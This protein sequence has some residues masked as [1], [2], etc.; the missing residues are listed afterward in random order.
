VIFDGLTRE[1]S[2]EE[3]GLDPRLQCF[4]DITHPIYQLVA[5]CNP[6]IPI[7]S[8]SDHAVLSNSVVILLKDASLNPPFTPLAVPQDL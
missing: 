7:V 8:N 5:L 4:Y 3:V 6:H 1:K 2:G